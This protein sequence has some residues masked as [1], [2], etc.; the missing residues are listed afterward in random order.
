MTSDLLIYQPIVRDTYLN[1][2]KENFDLIQSLFNRKEDSNLRNET[3]KRR[4]LHLQVMTLVGI[5]A[6]HL[7][8]LILLKRGFM[9][10]EKT[11]S[12]KFDPQ[13][14]DRLYNLNPSTISHSDLQVHIDNLYDDA[15]KHI[16]LDFKRE[17]IKFDKCISLFRDSSPPNYYDGLGSFNLVQPPTGYVEYL[18]V[19]EL[20]PQN[21]LTVIQQM[22]NNYLHRAEAMYEK[23]GVIQ[24]LINFL[25][26]LSRKEYPDFFGTVD[27][28]GDGEIK[29]LF[30]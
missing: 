28:L 27:Y 15:I 18:G 26:W 16:Q 23:I 21:C 6:E 10:N 22:R 12:D 3:L 5:T 30:R 1:F 13:F 8:K 17:L 2:I 19:D 20:T 14:M 9:L 7:I 4:A 24:Y 29:R 25:I 11:Y